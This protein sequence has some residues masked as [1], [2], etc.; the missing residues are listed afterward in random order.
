MIDIERL[1]DALGALFELRSYRIMIGPRQETWTPRRLLAP[2]ALLP[3]I[4]RLA[5]DQWIPTDGQVSFGLGIDHDENALC[6]HVLNAVH[7]A[8][9]SVIVLCVDN[10]LQQLVDSKGQISIETL[11]AYAQELH[12]DA[13]SQPV[14]AE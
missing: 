2:D 13:H 5:E 9:I 4:V 8:P 14:H 7:Y 10:M 12:S 3:V 1:I 6:G 11:E